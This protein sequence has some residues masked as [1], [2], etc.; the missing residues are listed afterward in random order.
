MSLTPDIENKKE[1]NF[2]LPNI[3][4]ENK[5]PIQLKLMLTKNTDQENDIYSLRLL[6]SSFLDKSPMESNITP[7]NMNAD[8]L[9]KTLQKQIDRIKT[10]ENYNRKLEN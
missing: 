9:N 7:Q 2:P 5:S 10:N 3:N 1:I 4:I 8:I 6:Q